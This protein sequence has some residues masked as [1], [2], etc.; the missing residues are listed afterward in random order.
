MQEEICKLFLEKWKKYPELR[1][2]QFIQKEFPTIKI[3][4][5]LFYLK[6]ELFK[7]KLINEL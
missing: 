3:P 4:S 5:E 6:D 1:F 7:E 2:F